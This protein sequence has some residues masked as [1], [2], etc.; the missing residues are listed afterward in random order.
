MSDRAPSPPLDFNL[1]LI[2]DRRASG[3]R[4]LALVVEEALK[5][6]VKAVQLREKDL[7]SRDLYELAY[8]MRKLTARY[9]AGLYINDRVDIALAVDADG[10][11]LG[12]SSLPIH[13][14]RKMLGKKRLIG[15]SCHNPVNA[16]AAQDFGADFITYGPVFHTPSKAAY[17]PP[18]GIDSLREVTPPRLRIPVF[19]LGGITSKN[20]RQVISAGVHG[21]ALISAVIAAENPREEAKTL[22]ALLPPIVHNKE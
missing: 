14:A 4:D 16:V 21:I 19:A 17:G 12:E 3:G 15:V 22:L 7:S 6:G 1:Y 11:H 9:S 2:T 20:A 8:A 13:R 10:V 18:V 5:G